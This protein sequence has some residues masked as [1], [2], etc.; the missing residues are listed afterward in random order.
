MSENAMVRI[1][2][3]GKNYGALR[4]L[5]DVSLNVRKGTVCIIIGPSGSGKC[6]LLRCVN[7]LEPYDDGSI[8]IDEEL[9]GY[10]EENGRRRPRKQREI[11]RMRAQTGMV[12]QDF[13]LF[14]HMTAL[15]NVAVAPI[16]VQGIPWAEANALAEEGLIKVGLKERM[17][18]Y[19][20]FLSGGEQQRVA[21]ARALGV[22][23]KVL[24]LDEVTSALD[25]ERIAEVLEVIR[26]LAEEGLTMLIVTHEIPFAAEIADQVV[27]LDGGRLVESGG[28][29]TLAKPST[30][31]LRTFL[32]KL[33]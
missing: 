29:E 25:P 33:A 6:T 24:L 7:F 16:K 10:R 15:E 3:I 28:A 12:F 27:F 23:P 2:G 22:Q 14:T 31:R 11:A 19:P 21:I 26:A 30:E 8:F 17:Y 20:A 1:E 32:G 9:V 18:A 4:V 5:D 13:N